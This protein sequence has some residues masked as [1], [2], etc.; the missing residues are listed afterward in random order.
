MTDNGRK[1]ILVVDDKDDDN[2]RQSQK[3]EVDERI[4]HDFNDILTAIIG[5]CH[6]LKIQTVQNRIAQDTIAELLNAARKAAEIAQGCKAIRTRQESDV[7]PATIDKKIYPKYGAETILLA[8]DDDD[9]RSILKSVLEDSGYKVIEATNG[10]EAVRLFSE[11]SDEI[12]MVLLDII[13]P[14]KD[15]GTA[16][17][18]MKKISSA[19]KILFISG[20][21]GDGLIKD[22]I[23][24]D[25]LNYLPK[26]V[27]PDVLLIKIRAL[28]DK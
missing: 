12:Q 20:C 21:P 16:Y 28:L 11:R 17:Y 19:S 8:D 7:N 26:P 6:L 2:M 3:I 15:G 5:F 27:D 4:V 24:E 22:K 14:E 23:I 10:K 9:V 13:M 1:T 25:G 18:E